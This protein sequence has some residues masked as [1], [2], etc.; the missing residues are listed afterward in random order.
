MPFSLSTVAASLDRTR[1]LVWG[2]TQLSRDKFIALLIADRRHISRSDG[3]PKQS[4]N[5]KPSNIGWIERS[6]WLVVLKAHLVCRGDSFTRIFNQDGASFSAGDV[7][8]SNYLSG[9]W[10]FSVIYY[11]LS[12]PHK[13]LLRV[14]GR[15]EMYMASFLCYFEPKFVFRLKVIF[16]LCTF[17]NITV[18]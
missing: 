14:H 10:V 13:W 3:V 8:C 1:S 12:L 16:V 15:D 5:Q 2:V 6:R 17:A 18:C 7:H 9:K 4:T 11:S